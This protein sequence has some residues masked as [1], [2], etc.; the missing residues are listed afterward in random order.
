MNANTTQW[1]EGVREFLD[2]VPRADLKE[3]AFLEPA[4]TEVMKQVLCD[5]NNDS[6][7]IG[8]ELQE[9]V[10]NADVLAGL[11]ASYVNRASVADTLTEL[12]SMIITLIPKVEEE[13]DAL[14][15]Q[16]DLDVPGTVPDHREVGRATNAK[17]LAHGRKSRDGPDLRGEV[18]LPEGQVCRAYACDPS[19]VPGTE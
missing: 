15:Q 3:G 13:A 2:A 8:L 1:S 11:V 14:G 18:R 9:F 17:R 16:A 10:D 19:L 4:S 12:T 5:L 6:H 7:T